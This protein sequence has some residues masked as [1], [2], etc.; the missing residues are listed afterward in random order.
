M[1]SEDDPFIS[2]TFVELIG[3]AEQKEY[4]SL[5]LHELLHENRLVRSWE[6]SM[7]SLSEY[8]C[9]NIPADDS[10]QSYPNEDFYLEQILEE[11]RASEQARFSNFTISWSLAVFIFY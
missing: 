4:I 1:R 10:R 8:E 6:Y 5:S 11:E 2:S 7:L 9:A 3:I